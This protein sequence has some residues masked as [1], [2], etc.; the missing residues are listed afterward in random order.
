VISAPGKIKGALAAAELFHPP[1]D[2]AL[3]PVAIAGR[4][5]FAERKNRNRAVVAEITRQDRRHRLHVWRMLLFL[6]AI[7]GVAAYFV[8]PYG[9]K[10]Y[11]RRHPELE[12][13]PRI[14]HTASGIPGDALNVELIGTE[15]DLKS[16][17]IAAHW[18]PADSLTLRS[19]LEIAEATV[20]KRAYDDAPVSNLYLF[21]RREDLAFEKPVGKNPRARHHVRFWR[22]PTADAEDRT[23]WMGAA[24]YDKSVGFSHR[25]GQ[26]THHTDAN[27]DAERDFLLMDLQ[28]MGGLASIDIVDGFHTALSGKNGGGDPWNTD[29]RL[30]V[31]VLEPH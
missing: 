2:G 5:K 8:I 22:A 17:M 12:D 6:L 21:G 27:I 3:R 1:R 18:Y 31:G 15:R 13:I 23:V 14:T 10:R 26:I 9:W 16:A 20:L 29:G 4:P 28:T 11:A 30:F 7:Y 19:C 25:T 24:T